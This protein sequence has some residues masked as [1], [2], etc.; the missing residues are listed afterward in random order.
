M[1]ILDKKKD[2][3]ASAFKIQKSKDIEHR[4][5]P[6]WGTF[7]PQ[8]YK[9]FGTKDLIQHSEMQDATVDSETEDSENMT[10]ELVDKND[11]ESIVHE[12]ASAWIEKN[13]PLILQSLLDQELEKKRKPSLKR[14]PAGILM[15]ESSKK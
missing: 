7:Q 5:D 4:V 2:L 10:A 12:L 1:D 3:S 8:E 13:A 9:G 6:V 14:Q 11:L 15:K